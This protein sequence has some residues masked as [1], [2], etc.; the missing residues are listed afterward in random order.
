MHVIQPMALPSQ[1]SLIFGVIKI[2]NVLLFQY[3]LTQFDLEKM[4]LN[5]C[6]FVVK[7][8]VKWVFVCRSL[9]V[10][11]SKHWLRRVPC[12]Y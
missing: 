3:W 12:V 11:T 7:D 1:N 4:S 9:K 10:A 8:A 5:G 6:L 2:E